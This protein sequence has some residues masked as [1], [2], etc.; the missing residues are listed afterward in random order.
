MYR[1]NTPKSQ[2]KSLNRDLGAGLTIAL[3]EASSNLP[4]K[5]ILVC[6]ERAF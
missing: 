6:H 3:S 2:N 1:G 4:E 5:F